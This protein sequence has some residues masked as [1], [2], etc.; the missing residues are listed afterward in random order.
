MKKL[1]YIFLLVQIVTL[2][3]AQRHFVTD[4]YVYNNFLM[5]P[6]DAGANRTCFL[7][8]GFFQ[9]QWFDV[10]LAPTTQ[11]LTFQAPLK[12]NVGSGTYLLNDRNGNNRKIGLQQSFSVL[13]TLDKSMRRL[14]TL[15]FGLSANL[16]QSSVN[17][18]SL[19]GGIINDPAVT[20]AKESGFGFNA[21]SGLILRIN[22]FHLGAAV[23]NI[24]PQNNPLYERLWE[25]PL[26]T[27]IHLHTGISFKMPN[28]EIY[29]EPLLYYRRNKLLNSRMDVNVKLTLPTVDPNY[30]VWGLLAYRRSMDYN[31][32]KDLG[33]ATTV[34]IMFKGLSVGLEYQYGLTSA[35]K[36][37]G[38]A[39]LLVAGY[40]ICS[41]NKVKR[42]PCIDKDEIMF[43][44]KYSKRSKRIEVKK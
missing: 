21:N 36:N 44:E 42:V 37:L 25:P 9:K 3:N 4:K 38:S 24:L 19:T 12:S 5:N 33:M 15:A 6:A 41:G 16:E 27:D 7:I 13:I 40:S 11:M 2:T 18:T 8:N 28:R 43:Q 14:T 20:G 1:L 34:G 32:G 39:F 17:Q 23:T 31:F 29:L 30:T 10:D 26:A 35:Q 22:D